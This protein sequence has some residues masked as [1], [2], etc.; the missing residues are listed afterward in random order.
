[1]SRRRV[2]A[3][4]IAQSYR[5]W[6]AKFNLHKNSVTGVFR[7]DVLT[8]LTYHGRTTEN[9]HRNTVRLAGL[10]VNL[11]GRLKVR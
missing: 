4:E 11:S 5:T 6:A 3:R 1:M 9:F 8:C 10:Q 7:P 2:K